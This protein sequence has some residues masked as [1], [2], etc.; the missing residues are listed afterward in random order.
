MTYIHRHCDPADT[1]AA[2]SKI[3]VSRS[4][5]INKVVM[6]KKEHYHRRHSKVVAHM[7]L[8]TIDPRGS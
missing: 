4:T 1:A 5:K 2:S 6:Y 8:A 7:T 3:K